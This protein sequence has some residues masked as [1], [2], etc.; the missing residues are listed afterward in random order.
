M[1]WCALLPV[2]CALLASNPLLAQT[3][4]FAPL[5]M[6]D[7]ET[8]VREVKPML[9]YLEERLGVTFTIDYNTSYSEILHNFAAGEL[10]LAYLGPLPYVE[11]RD[12]F[13]AVSPL[14]VFREPDGEAK[15]TCSVVMFADD[16]QPLR[17]L[18]GQALALTQPLSTCGY[19]ATESLLRH[20]GVSLEQARYRYLGRHDEVALAVVRGEFRA[21]GLKTTIARH[22]THLGLVQISETEPLPAFALVANTTTVPP[23]LRTRLTEALVAVQPRDNP[24]DARLVRAW[25][26]SLR[27]GAQAVEDADY[28]PVRRLRRGVQIPV[29][30]PRPRQGGG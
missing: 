18:A 8:V 21:G 4:R 3:L 29:P 9:E 22:Y 26:E 20:A 15:Y 12:Q 5:P 25:G 11:L 14:V 17:E 13:P 19:L 7:P 6:Q 27:H 16:R 24:E 30:V 10:D 1:R 2:L 28:E 23:E